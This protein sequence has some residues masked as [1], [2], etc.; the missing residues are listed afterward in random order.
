MRP[1][2]NQTAAALGVVAAVLVRLY[3]IHFHPHILGDAMV[4]G[5]LARNMLQH[6]TFAL[7][8]PTRIRPTLMRLPGYPL[9][10]AACFALFGA[11]N[12]TSVVYLQLI[13]DVAS[14]CL[15]AA[16]AARLFGKRTGLIALWLAALCPF[17][18]DYVA[19]GYTEIASIFCVALAFF[20]LE[21]W[22]ANLQGGR[23]LNHYLWPLAFA[24]SFGCLLRPDRIL[25]AATV[26]AAMLCI[27]WRTP[28]RRRALA[29]TAIVCLILILPLAGWALRNWRVFHVV[30]PLAPK[31]ANDPTDGVHYGFYRWYRT[32]A[33]EF[34]STFDIYWT[35]DGSVM[36]FSDLPARAYDLPGERA[37]TAALFA[38]YN[39]E[40]SATP[41]IDSAFAA[42]AAE[43]VKAHP[44]QYYVALPIARLADMWL[45]PRT[46]MEDIPLDWWRF[47][48]D[49]LGCMEAAA[50]GLINLAYLALAA[51]GLWRWKTQ[52]WLGQR[53]LAWSMLAF[54]LLRSA[55]LLT[56]DNSEP[57]YTLDC[58]P[59][60][61]LLASFA[62]ARSRQPVSINAPSAP[63]RPQPPPRQTQPP[64]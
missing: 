3:C 8:E 2:R 37:R 14:C 48:D 12:Y 59:I 56:I 26:L 41:A 35:W 50:L 57:R 19:T 40:T 31:Y 52:A 33:V 43:R 5:D 23:R 36:N 29:Q 58:Y 30:Q 54:V 47:N 10:M 21:R 13:L 60:V 7:T 25:L 11:G 39:R 51:L 38:A 55:L 64:G 42:L 28:A 24:L 63:P 27:A 22:H 46:E 17:T 45:R 53:V 62:F 49:R 16:L 4:Y 61:I 44:L 20:S 18:A 6:H 9:L 1:N 34:K 32:W 15:I